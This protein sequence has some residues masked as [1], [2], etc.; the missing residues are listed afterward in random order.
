M[1]IIRR[2]ISILVLLSFAT[3]G[4]TASQ[5]PV[6]NDLSSADS[7]PKPKEVAFSP[8]KLRLIDYNPVSGNYLFRGNMPVIKG[9]FA[10]QKLIDTMNRRSIEQLHTPLP[11]NIYIYDFSLI[12]K[13][14]ERH[15]LKQE[16]MFAQ[17]NPDLMQLIHHPVYGAASNPDYYPTSVLH[18][19]LKL[20]F[21]GDVYK[22]V[23]KLNKLL[24]QEYSRPAAIFVHCQAG[25][26][27][28]GMV[29]GTYQMQFLGKSYLEVIEEAEEIAGRPLRSLQKRALKWI[30]Y[31]LRDSK[32]IQSVGAIY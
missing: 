3:V 25:S 4:N 23:D 8:R 21:I 14:G 1:T 13:L 16:Q 12:S 7:R 15:L 32:G 27:R 22:L 5:R 11:E 18:I 30:A 26:D 28:T 9:R 17:I 20:P 6:A 29:I 19:M 24:N 31:Y 2:L 10:Y